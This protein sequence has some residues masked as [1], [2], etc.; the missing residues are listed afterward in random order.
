[1]CACPWPCLLRVPGPEVSF[2]AELVLEPGQLAV[3]P[4]RQSSGPPRMPP[5]RGC[6]AA[7]R[8]RGEHVLAQKPAEQGPHLGDAWWPR[9]ATLMAIA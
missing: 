1:M 6:R 2:P 5:T 9:A 7:C 8:E 3:P 4:D